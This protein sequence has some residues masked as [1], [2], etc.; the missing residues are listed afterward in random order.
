MQRVMFMQDIL[1]HVFLLLVPVEVKD[2]E[3]MPETTACV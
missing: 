3:L 1:C 2:C